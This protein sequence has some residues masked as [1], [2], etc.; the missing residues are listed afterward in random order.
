MTSEKQERSFR[1]AAR[2]LRNAV[3]IGVGAMLGIATLPVLPAA[4]IEVPPASNEYF[5]QTTGPLA[6]LNIGDFYTNVAGE[7]TDHEIVIQVP[8]T[9]GTLPPVVID[10]FDPE[11]NAA[12]NTTFALDEIRGN[13]D[14]AT[15]SLT[16]PSGNPVI[17][18]VYSPWVRRLAPMPS[19]LFIISMSKLSWVA[20][21][22]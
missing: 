14:D 8:C 17:T 10:L 13:A 4:A 6:G 18:T 20:G 2:S 1:A 16:D 15:F 22:K 11:L 9:T 5:F 7:N 3:A 12:G 21:L 19:R